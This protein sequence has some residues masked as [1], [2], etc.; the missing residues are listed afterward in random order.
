MK[1]QIIND[2]Y[3]IRQILESF[4]QSDFYHH[5]SCYHSSTGFPLGCCVDSTQLLGLFLKWRYNKDCQ[6]VT[7]CGLRDKINQSHTWLICDGFIIDITADQFIHND[8]TVAKVIIEKESLFH[9]LF[10]RVDCRTLNVVS[11]EATPVAEMVN[12]VIMQMDQLQ[13]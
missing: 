9:Q 2:I 11:L 10:D 8:N 12:K 5:S 1:Q 6:Y 13:P 7:A 3:L 4:E